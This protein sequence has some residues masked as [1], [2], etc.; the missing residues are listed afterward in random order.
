MGGDDDL[1]RSFSCEKTC[2]QKEGEHWELGLGTA[3]S[4]MRAGNNTASW[5]V[6]CACALLAGRISTTTNLCLWQSKI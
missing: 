5:Y 4:N 6:R 3:N 2:V 1:K